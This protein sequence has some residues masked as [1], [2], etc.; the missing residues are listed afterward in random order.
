M[1]I[2][3]VIDLDRKVVSDELYNHLVCHHMTYKDQHL[4]EHL[5]NI[6]DANDHAPRKF[7]KAISFLRSIASNRNSSYIR[8][9][10]NH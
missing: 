2:V 9:I 5:I 7:K 10:H 3:R 4:K 6:D 8:F 1:D